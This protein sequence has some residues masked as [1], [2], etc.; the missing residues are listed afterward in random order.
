[1]CSCGPSLFITSTKVSMIMGSKLRSGDSLR[2][3]R[4][5][6]VPS[7]FSTPAISTAM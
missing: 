7:A 2:Q 3:N 1:M 5:V 4:W 6:S